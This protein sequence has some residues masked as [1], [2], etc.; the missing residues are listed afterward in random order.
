[1]G[2]YITE[3]KL[4]DEFKRLESMDA[5]NIN[6]VSPTPYVN[7]IIKALELYKPDIPVIYNCGG[8][9]KAETIRKLR[10]YIDIYL[11][12]FKYSDD[13]LAVKYS[14]AP[15]YVKIASE[16]ISEMYSQAGESKYNEN[17]IMEK[18][19]IIRHLILP[20]HTRN[21]IEVLNIIKKKF[22]NVL[23][24]LMGQYIPLHKAND[25]S[26]LS[27]KITKREYEKVENHMLELELDGFT[28]ELNSASEIYV[29]VWDYNTNKKD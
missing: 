23:V 21:S 17:G 18:G 15:D 10:G 6:L 8:Y 22:P 19:V 20:N 13:S 26:K 27:R 11:P 5:H 4:A 16:A 28:Q 14:K 7:S 9:E 12:D 25:F 29:P 24:S 3:E 2:A 1:M